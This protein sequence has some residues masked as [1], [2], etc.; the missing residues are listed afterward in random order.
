ML[1]LP[2]QYYCSH[3]TYHYLYI[4]PPDSLPSA[5]PGVGFNLMTLR[6]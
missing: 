4:M 3:N 2:V 5:E 6:S 1:F